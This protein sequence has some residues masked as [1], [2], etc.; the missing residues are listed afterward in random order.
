MLGTEL[1]KVEA[2]LQGNGFA[3]MYVIC[4]IIILTYSCEVAK[5]NIPYYT[6]ILPFHSV[7]FQGF[8][9]YGVGLWS[10]PAAVILQHCKCRAGQ[11]WDKA[12]AAYS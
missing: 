7:A 12:E 4:V 3:R 1:S 2:G 8:R 6:T 9:D 10:S 5:P 11:S